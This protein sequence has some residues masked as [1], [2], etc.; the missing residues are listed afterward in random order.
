MAWGPAQRECGE[1][2]RRIKKEIKNRGKIGTRENERQR[3]KVWLTAGMMNNYC[4]VR[5]RGW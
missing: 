5:L 1:E 2:R 4:Q 3:T